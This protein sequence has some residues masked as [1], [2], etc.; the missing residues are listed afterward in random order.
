MFA[1]LFF[2]S[3]TIMYVPPTLRESRLSHIHNLCDEFLH[4]EATPEAG[5]PDV[6]ACL[7]R[8]R[9]KSV[10]CVAVLTD[11]N[12]RIVYQALY[13]N[14]SARPAVH[15]ETFLIYD[16]ELRKHILQGKILTLLMTYQPFHYSGGHW[17]VSSL[18]CTESLIHF[19]NKHL[20]PHGVRVRIKVAYL[21]R[22]HWVAAPSKYCVMI[23]NARTGLRLLMETFPD[24]TMINRDDVEW[25][26]PFFDA[27]V[28]SRWD[29]GEF[30]GVFEWRQALMEFFGAT[31]ATLRK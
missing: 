4:I 21:Y 30:E 27:D 31:L 2:C 5:L 20:A 9:R 6:C 17:R 15:A 12:E 7:C 19:Y 3:P 22:A 11:E 8:C 29:R 24:V 25:L 23:E 16:D 10:T 18:S 13:K 26:L 1:T 14:S 28:R